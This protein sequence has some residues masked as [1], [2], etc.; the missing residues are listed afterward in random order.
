MNHEFESRI[1]KFSELHE[2]SYLLIFR[3]IRP[4]VKFVIF[5]FAF[6][7]YQQPQLN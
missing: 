1:N 2:F 3:H 7:H 6:I 4:F 5:L